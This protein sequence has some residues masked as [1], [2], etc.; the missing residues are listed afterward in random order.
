MFVPKTE[1][2]SAA[3]WSETSLPHSDFVSNKIHL[4]TPD[5]PLAWN[6]SIAVSLGKVRDAAYNVINLRYI[7]NHVTMQD[8]RGLIAAGSCKVTA[9]TWKFTLMWT[10]R[11][12]DLVKINEHL[13]KNET[14]EWHRW[15]T[16]S[17]S[18]AI[19]HGFSIALQLQIVHV[20]VRPNTVA[21]LV[22]M[23]LP[24][25]HRVKLRCLVNASSDRHQA[26][27]LSIGRI[28][29]EWHVYPSL[30]LGGGKYQ[31]KLTLYNPT[32]TVLPHIAISGAQVSGQFNFLCHVHGIS[33]W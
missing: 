33:C 21:I 15:N 20:S 5:G 17:R 29:K 25:S 19:S 14:L 26:I 30:Q 9:C 24:F 10:L 22:S 3:K 4:A 2:S 16:A 27:T 1:V 11:V 12:E 23:P 31:R 6:N 32:V 28:G 7:T 13:R 18:H 8:S